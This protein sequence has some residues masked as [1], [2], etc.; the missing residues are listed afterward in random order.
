MNKEEIEKAKEDLRFFNEGDYIT[1]EMEHSAIVLEEYIKELE[2]KAIILDKVTDKLKKEKEY[3]KEQ[4]IYW[5]GRYRNAEN[6]NKKSFH[7]QINRWQSRFETFREIL[8]FIEG[9]KK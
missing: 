6:Y 4:I 9:E 2:N 3:A 8:K 5:E 1:K 7:R